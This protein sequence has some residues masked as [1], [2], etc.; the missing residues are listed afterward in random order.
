MIVEAIRNLVDKLDG[1]IGEQ[2][3]GNPF[4]SNPAY[5]TFPL[6]KENFKPIKPVE[7]K[8]KFVFVDGGN[9]EIL[10]ALSFVSTEGF[11]AHIIK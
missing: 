10:G 2:D 9:Q 11:K 5:K 1:N 7:S 4:F 8:R 6:S 3:V